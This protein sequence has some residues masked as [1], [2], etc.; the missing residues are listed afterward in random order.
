MFVLSGQKRCRRIKKR[1]GHQARTRV[2]PPFL[3]LSRL[4]EISDPLKIC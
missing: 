4:D 3:D 2:G 1:T